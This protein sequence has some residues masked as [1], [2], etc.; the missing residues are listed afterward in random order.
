VRETLAELAERLA[1]AAEFEAML[2][3]ARAGL[4]AVLP[5]VT[6]RRHRRDRH[7]LHIVPGVVVA[8][9]MWAVRSRVPKLAA[10]AVA[11]ALGG[12]V[13]APELPAGVA[14]A[15]RPPAAMA[16]AIRHHTPGA[17]PERGGSAA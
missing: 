3:R 15:G 10:A 5:P 13:L 12:T 8:A 1:H 4:P 11:V 9:V 17:H 14:S 7:G 16:P 2:T 6:A